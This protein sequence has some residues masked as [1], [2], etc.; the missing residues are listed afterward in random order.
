MHVYVLTDAV[1][2]EEPR[3]STPIVMSDIGESVH[4][5]IIVCV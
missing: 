2:I 5:C 4:V 1:A 3:T